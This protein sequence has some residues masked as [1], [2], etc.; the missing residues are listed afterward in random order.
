MLDAN[1]AF[2][3]QVNLPDEQIDLFHAALLIC[4]EEYPDLDPGLY[5]PVIDQ[6]SETMRQRLPA[7]ADTEAM[8]RHLN[9]F[10]YD[11]LG[12]KGNSQDYYDPRNS[13]LNEV[14][15]RRRGIPITLSV[16]YMELGIRLGLELHG[17][18]FPGHFLVKL[19][20]R[21]GQVVLD[22]FNGGAALS[23]QELS[24]RLQE[25]FNTEFNDI[26]PFLS[27]ATNKDILVRILMNLKGV[28]QHQGLAEK[29]LG[30][31]NKILIVN[32]ALIEQ[33]RDRGLLLHAL[34]CHHAALQDLQ[35]YL[36]AKPEADDVDAIR[37]L[38]FSLQE[39][40]SR[41]N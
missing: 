14:M 38:I 32:P 19:P 16:I 20:Y 22:P 5:L 12:F 18:S 21:G 33:Y 36:R 11:E 31:V 3:D 27:A 7:G 13:Y 24:D 25:I 28:Y 34:E 2:Q 39:Q 6:W 35:S 29:A 26:S 10:M 4:A 23:E 41:L 8:V 30:I 17:V 40:H 9:R 15:E 1:K 37:T